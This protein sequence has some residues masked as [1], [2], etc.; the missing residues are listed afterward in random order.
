[1]Y[2]Y[3]SILTG[4]GEAICRVHTLVRGESNNWYQ[5]QIRHWTGLTVVCTTEEGNHLIIVDNC[6]CVKGPLY[7]YADK[8]VHS[9]KQKHKSKLTVFK[10]L[11]LKCVLKYIR[12]TGFSSHLYLNIDY[13]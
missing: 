13:W 4:S 11:C 1:M 3:T 10:T 6:L 5:Q 9:C 8:N 7:Y 12:I 2:A